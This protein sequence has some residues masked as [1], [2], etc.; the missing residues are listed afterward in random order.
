MTSGVD[1][2]G[3]EHLLAAA[4]LLGL[5]IRPE[6]RDGVRANLQVSLNFGALVAAF[7]LADEAEPAP[8]F[9]A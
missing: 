1:D 3:A 5:D 8:V 6:W 4:T 2:S 9:V 7:P